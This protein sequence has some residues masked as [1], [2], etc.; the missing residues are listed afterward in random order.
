MPQCN[1]MRVCVSHL[2]LH[3]QSTA[4]ANIPMLTGLWCATDMTIVSIN[5]TNRIALQLFVGR[6]TMKRT[7]ACIPIAYVDQPGT[8]FVWNN[9]ATV[10]MIAS[11]VRMKDIDAAKRFA[12]TTPNVRTSATIHRKDLCVRARC[13]CIWNPTNCNAVPNM[14][15]GRGVRV[16]RNA[17]RL[18]NDTSADARTV[19][20]CNLISSR[21]KVTQSIRRTSSLATGKRSKAWIWK[22][23]LWKISLPLSGIQSLW[24]FCTPMIRWRFFGRM[25]LM[26]KYIGK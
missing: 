15:A 13:I 6:R 23:W 26:T 21:A 1:R 20:R 24:T 5:R 17:T 14:H 10:Q 3:I 7:I 25:W 22:R 8:V 4:F 11:T 19:S 16:R 2:L 12:I 18:A 9:C